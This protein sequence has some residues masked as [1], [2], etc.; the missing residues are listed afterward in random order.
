[1]ARYNTQYG[2]TLIT[3]APAA[4]LTTPNAGSYI[5]FTGG[6]YTVT[7]PNPAQFYGAPMTFYNSAGGTITLNTPG[8]QNFLGALGNGTTTF[9]LPVGA[10]ITIVGDS[11]GYIVTGTGGGQVA[12]TILTASTSANFTTSGA[13]TISPTTTGSL[14]NMTLAPGA[15]TTLQNVQEI[16]Q[17]I[18]S[19]GA[20]PTMNFAL[21]DIWYLTSLSTN[22]TALFTNV[23]TTQLRTTTM[24]IIQAQGPTPYIPTAIQVNGSAVALQYAGGV[25]PTG[26]ANKTD[27]V[28]IVVYN[29]SGTFLAF[30]QLSSYG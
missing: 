26:R 4:P 16:I 6:P 23:P 17:T 27:V 21:G 9:S 13:V 5:E 28:S 1:M 14:V 20:T 30:G 19:P 3:S 24:T 2:V 15:L 12:S 18:A 22:Y 11:V 25:N 10:L 29:I 7:L 8:S